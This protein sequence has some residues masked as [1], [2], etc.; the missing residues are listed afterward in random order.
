M[1]NLSQNVKIRLSYRMILFCILLML[2]NNSRK[3]L[4]AVMPGLPA[5][6]GNTPDTKRRLW[7][8]FMCAFAHSH[9]CRG[10]PRRKGG[11]RNGEI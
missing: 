1:N 2:Y 8:F 9:R 3:G 10:F 11:M 5:A 4:L 7:C 6:S